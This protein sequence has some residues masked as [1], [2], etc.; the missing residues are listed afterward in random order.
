M[1][2]DKEGTAFV[3]DGYAA[4]IWKVGAD[5][6][7]VAWAQGEPLKSPTGLAWEGKTLLVADPKAC[8]V[9]R[10]DTDGKPTALELE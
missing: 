8:A 1:E 5:G 3:S 2:V 10:V 6:K 7:P 9:F 4:T